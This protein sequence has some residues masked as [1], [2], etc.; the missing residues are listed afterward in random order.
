MFFIGSASE[1]GVWVHFAAAHVGRILKNMLIQAV[2]F[3]DTA[4]VSDTSFISCLV[5][6]TCHSGTLVLFVVVPLYP[7]PPHHLHHPPPAP[8]PLL[9]HDQHHHRLAHP[10][11]PDQPPLLFSPPLLPP[12]STP[13][14][15]SNTAPELCHLSSS[16]SHPKTNT[17]RLR[18]HNFSPA[19]LHLTIK[20]FIPITSKRLSL[21]PPA[22]VAEDELAEDAT[23]AAA[24]AA[25]ATKPKKGKA[26]LPL[27]RDRVQKL[28]ESKEEYDI[29]TAVSLL[30]QTASTKFVESAEAHFRLNI[31][32]KYN[33]Q[34][35][36]HPHDQAVIAG[37]KS[38]R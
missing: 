14:T 37:A 11:T 29:P 16:R 10:L 34:R 31:D 8:P 1:L 15:S 4:Y 19:S 35:S 23:A 17:F 5:G 3:I 33:D 7:L 36:H 13:P 21:P 32:P 25:P 27:K 22:A 24:A 12:R 6:Y 38:M 30:K 9:F 26:A 18:T 28:S 2:R 20:P